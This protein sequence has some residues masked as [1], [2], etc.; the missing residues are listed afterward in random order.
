MH[1][2]STT[3]TRTRVDK[4]TRTLSHARPHSRTSKTASIHAHLF[5]STCALHICVGLFAPQHSYF[6][7]VHT[8]TILTCALH[9]HTRPSAHPHPHTCTPLHANAS[10]HVHPRAPTCTHACSYSDVLRQDM[11]YVAHALLLSIGQYRACLRSALA[12]FQPFQSA[13][14]L[15]FHAAIRLCE[16]LL[17]LFKDCAGT[18]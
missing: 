17:H 18:P 2:L 3:H 8:C 14:Q 4:F 7:I 10:A 15:P 1:E 9:S 12:I 5:T 13:L 6:Q 11:Q 16:I